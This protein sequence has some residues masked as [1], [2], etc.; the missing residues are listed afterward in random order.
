MKLGK[1][2]A[3]NIARRS[4]KGKLYMFDKEKIKEGVRLILEGLGEDTQREGLIDTPD[5]VARMYEET[6]GGMN[7]DAASQLARVFTAEGSELVIEKDITFFS[8]CEHHMM[9]F[10]G[11]AHI[12][13]IPNGK[14]VGIS[15]LARCVEVYARRLQIQEQLTAQV[16]DAVFENLDAKGVMVVMEAEHMC[17]TMRGVKKPG[18]K[19]MTMALRG[20]F[21]N[22]TELKKQVLL[23]TSR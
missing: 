5:R 12:A 22:N 2:I 23:M 17:M 4:T 1:Y 19:T 8:T 20:E 11:K 7:E 16:A 15:K 3:V 6:M 9:P 13:Y 18:T 10:F 14:V 21:E